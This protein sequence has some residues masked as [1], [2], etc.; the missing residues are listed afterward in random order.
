[1][2]RA[3]PET[4]AFAR[5]LVTFEMRE[6]TNLTLEIPASFLPIEK[7]RLPL[8]AIVG[9]AGVRALRSRALAL[10][11]PD[12]QWLRP[13]HVKTDGTFEG[14]HELG[15]QMGKEKLV[16]AGIAV[17]AQLIGLL[18]AFIGENL[19]L[20][21]LREVWPGLSLGSPASGGDEQ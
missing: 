4:R 21:L 15:A 3:T 1:M 8:A 14:L 5:R 16:E 2:S 17:L 9:S 20:G 12:I 11:V 10:A 19:T 13:L 7:L 18:V 6:N